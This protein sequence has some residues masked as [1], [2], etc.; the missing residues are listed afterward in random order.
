MRQTLQVTQYIKLLLL[1]SSLT[2]TDL[3]TFSDWHMIQPD[4][5]SQGQYL[6]VATFRCVQ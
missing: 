1:Q 3:V 4:V 5:F 6:Q 2:L